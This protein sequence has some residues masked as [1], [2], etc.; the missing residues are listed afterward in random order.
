[1]WKF[2]FCPTFTPYSFIFLI[3]V[4]NTI[5]YL[6]SLIL[7]TTQS[8]RHMNDLVFL[9]PDLRTLNALGCLNPWEIHQNY[10]VW[11]LFTTLFL[12]VG[13]S[14]YAI[15]SVALMIVGFMIEST[16]VGVVRMALFYFIC[17]GVASI[18]SALVSSELSC[19]NFSSVMALVSGMLALV[20]RN[21]KALHG[22][23]PMR[24]C[25]IF[26]IVIIFII[27]LI[28][29]ASSISPGPHF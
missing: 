18:F 7:T 10:Q 13:L 3:W 26:I 25:L 2:A 15:S 21:W 12:S 22:A 8:D 4:M 9:G 16:R 6:V 23:G 19:G 11:R 29:T 28:G 1:M 27:V 17:G 20:I 14:N 24:I 5:A